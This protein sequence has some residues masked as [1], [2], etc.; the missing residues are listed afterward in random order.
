VPF[1]ESK[2]ITI[3]VSLA[4]LSSYVKIDYGMLKKPLALGRVNKFAV[5]CTSFT[6]VIKSGIPVVSYVSFWQTKIESG[7]C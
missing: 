6:F 1:E 7:K 5:V 3:Q 2:N 4:D